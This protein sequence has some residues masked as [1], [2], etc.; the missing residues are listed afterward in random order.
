MTS[1]A[2]RGLQSNYASLEIPL[3]IRHDRHERRRR[4]WSSNQVRSVVCR[5][6]MRRLKF[7]WAS[8]MT[9]SAQRGL[10][11]NHASLEIPLGIRHDRH[12]RRR[13]AWSSNQVRSVVCRATMRRLKFH[14]ASGM[15]SSAQRGLQSNHAS[16]EI[17]LAIR[18]DRHV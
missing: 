14:W 6:T 3:G 9:S 16:L 13:R 12:E 11:S 1:S 7:H 15:T 17:P 5:A 4:A 10:Q 18:H 8:G 2:Q